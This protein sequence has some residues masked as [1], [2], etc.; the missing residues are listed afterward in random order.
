MTAR[1]TVLALALTA[2]NSCGG[3]GARTGS[4]MTD[5]VTDAGKL[6]TQAGV[7][8]PPDATVEYAQAIAGRDS[9]ARMVL[10]LPEASWRVW[11]GQ[12]VPDKPDQPPFTAAENYELGPDDGRWTPSKA[13]GLT[14][15]QVRWRGSEALNI[16][17]SPLGDGR[18]RVF[19]FWFQT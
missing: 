14:T 1:V 15:V 8:I 4:D 19:I 5:T 3:A 9:A 6:A 13:P 17:Q 2:A 10:V 18:V 11:R 12:L 16:G 7:T